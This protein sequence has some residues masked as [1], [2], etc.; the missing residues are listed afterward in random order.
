MTRKLLSLV[1]PIVTLTVLALSACPGPEWP[2][3][4][5]D[6]HCKADK[7]GNAS[8]QDLICV[9]GQC[10]ECAKDTDCKGG[11]VCRSYR[12]VVK[13]ECERDADCGGNKVCGGGKCKLE[14]TDDAACGAGRS[15]QKNRCVTGVSC[16][17]DADCP[18]GQG[19]V[20]GFCK[21]AGSDGASAGGP[22]E[23]QPRIFFDFNQASITTEA[24][25]TLDQTASCLKERPD[26]KITIEG[27]CDERGTAEFNL[28]LGERRADSTRKYLQK[29]GVDAKRVKI[30]SYGEEKPLDSG[31][32]ESAWSQNRRAEFVTR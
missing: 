12:C 18:E 3:C 27:H 6:D 10:Q 21:K 26:L 17:E 13:P 2:K 23:V 28:A 30:I 19:C 31:S 8:G 25:A 1:L 32:S 16:A 11:K 22:C 29:L 24:R 15:C 5:N 7:D 20:R 14:C 4:E 9:F